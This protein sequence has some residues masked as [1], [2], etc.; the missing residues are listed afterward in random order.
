[1]AG[2]IAPGAM[3]MSPSLTS[4]ALPG[5]SLTTD[6]S[7]K[8]SAPRHP[9]V[10]V[11]PLYTSV[12]SAISDADWAIYKKSLSF[13]LLGNLNQE[14][15]SHTLGRILV[16]RELEHAHNA[17]VT[18][19]YANTWRDPPEA[20]I[21]SWV[22]SG[23]KP[24]T[25]VK[26]THDESEKR[27]KYEVMQLSR[28]ERKRLKT[29]PAATEGFGSEGWNGGTTQEYVDARRVKEPE[30]G[31]VATNGAQGGG[32]GKTST[33]KHTL[34]PLLQLNPLPSPPTTH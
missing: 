30:T 6:L 16:T 14:E 21:A 22:S 8:P 9:R 33:S 17:L 34:Y 13:F 24:S 32:F 31:P 1:M 7:K 15:L 12:K 3:N 28:R 23:D 2:T 29:I 20:G 4:S 11:E 5:L 26:G 10:D 18:A 27:L 25:T 19:I